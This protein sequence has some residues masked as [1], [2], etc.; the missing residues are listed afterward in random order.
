[1]LNVRLLGLSAFLGAVAPV[2]LPVVL[3]SGF[4][5]ETVVGVEK[6]VRETLRC[7]PEVVTKGC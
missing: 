2:S 3:A 7:L 5:T 4:R 1:M 6:M